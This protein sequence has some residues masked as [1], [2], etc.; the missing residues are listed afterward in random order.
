MS[1]L[2][3]NALRISNVATLGTL[4][5]PM[6]T[7]TWTPIRHL[8][9]FNSL[10][11]TA[12]RY[13]YQLKDVE[14]SVQDGK[15]GEREI[16]HAKLFGHAKLVKPGETYN[17]ETPVVGWRN[18]NNQQFSAGMVLGQQVTVCDNLIFCGDE[19]TFRMHTGHA[20]YEMQKRMFQCFEKMD[21][22]I[23]MMKNDMD[24]YQATYLSDVEFSHLLVKA[25][26]HEVIPQSKA[27]KVVKQW[28]EPEHEE[29]KP[30]TLYSANNAFTEVFKELS[31]TSLPQRSKKLTGL[32]HHKAGITV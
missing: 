7:S 26:Q 21:G 4:N 12:N 31:Y 8:D 10:E 25:M 27:L 6:G 11:H 14:M 13:G 9:F 24:V 3:G 1:G 30:R 17:R 18:S 19:E 16:E 2:M 23:E 32:C 20:L 5:T 29:F 15:L 22:A 28:H